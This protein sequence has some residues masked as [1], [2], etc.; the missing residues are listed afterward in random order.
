MEH[1]FKITRII[2]KG[3]RLLKKFPTQGEF[4]RIHI[5]TTEQVMNYLLHNGPAARKG[6][7]FIK[8]K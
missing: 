1:Y 5:P 3:P 2:F 4:M 7:F 8:N 6:G